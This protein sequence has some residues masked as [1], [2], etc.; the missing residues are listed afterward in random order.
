MP[1]AVRA[2]TATTTASWPYGRDDEV[3]DVLRRERAVGALVAQAQPADREEAAVADALVAVDDQ[4]RGL[5]HSL[6]RGAG[7]SAGR[8]GGAGSVAGAA[9]PAD[10]SSGAGAGA[11]G[12]R[13]PSAATVFTSYLPS[14]SW[15]A[16]ASSSTLPSTQPG[17]LGS[18]SLDRLGLRDALRGSASSAA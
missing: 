5:A 4:D 18:P 9:E 2:Y 14:A 13:A 15:I 6:S 12:G 10:G 1:R 11:G 3:A 16:S 17:T 7:R 8:R